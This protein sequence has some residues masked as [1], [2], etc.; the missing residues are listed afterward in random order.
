[1]Q[2]VMLKPDSLPVDSHHKGPV[3]LIPVFNKF[4]MIKFN[5][6]LSLRIRLLRKSFLVHCPA[7]LMLLAY[8]SSHGLFLWSPSFHL[9]WG[10]VGLFHCKLQISIDVAEISR[11]NKLSKTQ[12]N[13]NHKHISRNALYTVLRFGRPF[14]I[15]CYRHAHQLSKRL[16]K[17]DFYW[18]Q[19]HSHKTCHEQGAVSIRK[20]VLPGM[21]IPMLKIR[22]PNG[23][24][25]FNMEIAIRR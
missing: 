15:S 11:K 4:L 18:V 13:M 5:E 16:D 10:I 2:N 20:T 19:V 25:I 3:I 22:R 6:L 21:A 7:M 24:L 1:M 8:H 17:P 9:H 14:N 12:Q 23:R